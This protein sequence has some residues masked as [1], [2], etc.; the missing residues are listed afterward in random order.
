[1]V[2]HTQRSIKKEEHL[3]GRHKP[4]RED[5]I[6]YVSL[7][8]EPKRKQTPNSQMQRTDWWMPEAG[9]GGVEGALNGSKMGSK[10]TDF[11]L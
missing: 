6:P 4:D 7:V 1:M 10:G 9:G 3:A 8:V 5:K 2:A 11:Q